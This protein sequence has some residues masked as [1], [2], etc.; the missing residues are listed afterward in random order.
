[1]HDRYGDYTT[2]F[3]TLGAATIVSALFFLLARQPPEPAR[4]AAPIS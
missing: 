1:M 3:W 4:T 2:A